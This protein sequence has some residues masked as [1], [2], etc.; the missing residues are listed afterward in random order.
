MSNKQLNS[1]SLTID[2]DLWVELEIP[3]GKIKEKWDQKYKHKLKN[4]VKKDRIDYSVLKI[5]LE[6]LDIYHCTDAEEAL[7]EILDHNLTWGYN[8]LCLKLFSDYKSFEYFE[9]HNNNLYSKLDNTPFLKHYHNCYNSND[10]IGITALLQLFCN[11]G[12]Q[13]RTIHGLDY[14]D[15]KKPQLI[16]TDEN[17]VS[18]DL[19]SKAREIVEQ[20]DEN[21]AR[22]Y[23]HWHSFAYE[24][25]EYVMIKR[26][27]D[28]D[29]ERQAN[30]N[31]QEE[32]AEF[33]VLR[34]SGEQLEIISSTKKI[35]GR[36][37]TG[38]NR[39]TDDVEFE[40]VDAQADYDELETTV[41]GLLGNES[42]ESQDKSSDV[43][44]NR[45]KIVGV[46]LASSPLPGHPSITMKSGDGIR[47]TIRALREVNY[48]LLQSL[49]DIN[50]IYTEFD[51]R[52][53]SI[54][55]KE[56]KQTDDDV[57]WKFKYD[58]HSPPRSEREDF[59]QLLSDLFDIEPIF[60]HT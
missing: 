41:K 48:D 7:E 37:R 22:N 28:D 52:E 33:V 16:S 1:R 40:D 21:E 29:V 50:V 4:H 34:Y 44:L 12:D 10:K 8:L 45:F 15:K 20:M 58:A 59:E 18:L 43:D 17:N 9:S 32:P 42:L 39:T 51:G 6:L 54:R 5:Y 19:Q 25:C 56:R 23:E 38:V 47:Q 11:N 13:L 35:A 30:G 49:D 46:K 53:Y 36:A 55:P 24:N 2:E 57:Y 27:I 14:C 31:I 3:Y 26:E 60:E